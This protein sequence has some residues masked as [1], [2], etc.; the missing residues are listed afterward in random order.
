LLISINPLKPFNYENKSV[1]S[2]IRSIV[3]LCYLIGTLSV[4]LGQAGKVQKTVTAEIDA[5][6]FESIILE[7]NYNLHIFDGISNK[8]ILETTLSLA[9]LTQAE[10]VNNCLYVTTP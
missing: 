10:V 7:G 1:K 9:N 3:L 4:A 2:V 5:P 6:H 8:I